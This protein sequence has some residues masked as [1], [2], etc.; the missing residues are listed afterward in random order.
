MPPNKPNK[1]YYLEDLRFRSCVPHLNIRTRR[2]GAGPV[3][4]PV[5]VDNSFSTLEEGL[6]GRG[7]N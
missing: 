5:V 3:P 1:S 7:R 4:E 6:V 2:A